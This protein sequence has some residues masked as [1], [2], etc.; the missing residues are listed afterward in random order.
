[1]G[2]R[3]SH[4]PKCSHDF[5]LRPL[6]SPKNPH[7]WYS[8][9][10]IGIHPLCKIVAK[11]CKATGIGGWRTNH[12]LHST[13]ATRMYQSGIEEHEVAHVTGHASVAV[14]SYKH[15]SDDQKHNISD[16]LY[17]NKK[18]PSTAPNPAYSPSVAVNPQIVTKCD[19]QC[20]KNN[21]ESCHKF[22]CEWLG[23]D[24]Q[25]DSNPTNWC[26]TNSEPSVMCLSV[27]EIWSKLLML[28][29]CLGLRE[30]IQWSYFW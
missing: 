23:H 13:A 15:T 12:S 18:A 27:T 9:E 2:K 5:Y 4:N 1:M 26:A 20:T 10:P 30:C 7:I 14:R 8:C 3:P 25:C 6:V 21:C 28:I 22:A 24:W 17:A 29:I 16:V 19:C 11:M